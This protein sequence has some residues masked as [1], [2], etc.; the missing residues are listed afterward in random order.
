MD[1]AVLVRADVRDIDL[2]LLCGGKLDLG[3]LGCLL[4][5]LEGKLVLAEINAVRVLELGDEEV[6]DAVVDIIAAEVGVSV[7]RKNLE[8]LLAVNLVDIDDGDIERAA[9]EVVDR[10]LALA[11][12][13]VNAVGECRSGRLVDDALYVKSCD[14]ARILGCLALRVVEVCRNGDDRL[15]YLLAEDVLSGL[16]PLRKSAEE[17]SS[18]PLPQ[19]RHRR[20]PQGQS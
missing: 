12:D 11:L 7:G 8:G 2:G 19:P 14:A 13:L 4:E 15:G 17:P 3:L 18:C 20:C 16:L 9:A 10:D 5:S 1:R 6:D